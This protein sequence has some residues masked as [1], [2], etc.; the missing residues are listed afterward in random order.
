MR[1]GELFAEKMRLGHEVVTLD[2]AKEV[3]SQLGRIEDLEAS[4]GS[5]GEAP[6]QSPSGESTESGATEASA[7]KG[8]DLC[9]EAQ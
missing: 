3:I 6:V 2:L 1:L 4:E 9:R 7:K 5:E 8:G